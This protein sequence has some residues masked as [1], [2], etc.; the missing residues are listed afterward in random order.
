[1][2]VRL[3]LYGGVY[4]IGGNKVLLEDGDVRL[5]L[6]FGTPFGR[7][8]LYF[9]EYLNP[10]A[11]RGLFDLLALDLVPRLKGLYRQDLEIPGLWERF[12]PTDVFRDGAPPVDA[13]LLSHAHLDHIGDVALLDPQ[14][15]VVTTA[16]SA[17][18][19]R[20]MQVTSQSGFLQEW[21]YLNERTWNSDRGVL[22]TSKAKGRA[23]LGRPFYVLQEG[24]P[25]RLQE[26][27]AW[28][29]ESPARSRSLEARPPEVF[30][31]QIKGLRVHWHRVDH[32]IPGAAAFVV[33][34]SAG[35]V[36]YTGD[37]R[38]HGRLGKATWEMAEDWAR[39]G[40]N[41][42]LCEGTRLGDLGRVVDEDEVHENALRLTCAAAG[43]LV[44]A[45][46]AARNL[47]R[48]RTFLEVARETGRRL[49]VQ[50]KD[51]YLLEAL[52]LVS[53]DFR[54]ALQ[55]PH[56]VLY[57]DV[58][59]AP[60]PWEQTLRER[61]QHRLVGPDEVSADPG[62]YILCCSLWDMNDL[63]DLPPETV[64][65]GVY[66]YANSKAYDE[67]QAVDLERLRQWVRHLG[68]T[69]EG[70]PDAP[71]AARLHASGHASE[72][73]LVEFVRRVRPRV[74]VPVHTEKPARW[75]EL[76]KG[77]GIKVHIPKVPGWTF[78]L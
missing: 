57:D 76:L 30:R 49:A 64:E 29:Q 54:R 35:R 41:I 71:N 50:P 28:W 13:V 51:A 72:A 69:M 55:D 61:W 46:F 36:A 77:S 38:F 53:D 25:R 17:A 9:N 19:A 39:M 40:I 56:V 63:L 65:G 70:D 15:P 58:K 66:L 45:D 21:C 26:L 5:L 52:T 31:G 14:V 37:L 3:A 1:M 12:E 73:E 7:H 33:E 16:E 8:K 43:R 6:D 59:S 75:Q 42:L 47:E 18:V 10:R 78:V 74:L 60:R 24:E 27:A 2:S 48:L 4:E 44:V 22:E 20:A 34:T 11:A 67:E 23:Y 62:Q 68:L 32:S